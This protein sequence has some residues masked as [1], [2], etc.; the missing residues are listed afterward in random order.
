MSDISLAPRRILP[1]PR[2]FD[3][4]QRLPLVPIGVTLAVCLLILPI[5]FIL[6]LGSF[7]PEKALP[8]DNVGFTLANY[9]QLL[10]DPFAARLFGN[11]FVYAFSSLAVGMVIT[12]MMI[13]LVERTDIPY[14]TFIHVVMFLPIIKPAAISAFGWVI[15]LSP[16]QGLVNVPLRNLLGISGNEGPF[17]IY[18]FPG[19]VFLTAI[20]VVP[21]MFIMLSATFR[22]M[23][24]Q[25]EEAG[26]TA[27]ASAGGVLRQIT[28]PVLFPGILGAG[29]YYTIL[30]FELF[31]IPLIIGFNADYLVIST[32]LYRQVFSESGAPSYSVAAAFGTMALII[33]LGLAYIY[34][35]VTKAAYRYV[36]LTGRRSARRPV[37]LGAWKYPAFGFVLAYLL[38]SIILPIAAL[39]WT[40]LFRTW[41]IPSVNALSNM[42]FDVYR[43]V[44]ADPR[45]GRALQ[46]TFILV[47]GSATITVVLA[48]MISWV[49][50]RNNTLKGGGSKW[51]SLLDAMAFLPRSIPGVVIALAVFLTFIRTDLY[52]TIWII[53]IGHVISYMP[54][55]VRTMHSTLLQIHRELEE[56]AR[57]SGAGTRTVMTSVL[58]PL[59]RPAL[60][61]A[62]VWVAAHSVRDFTFPLM[63][64]ASGNI[65]VAQLLWQV[66]ERGYVER[67]AALSVMLMGGLI[68]LVLPARFF[69]LRKAI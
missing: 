29:I 16:R 35:R 51:V 45:W 8:F 12:I 55:A 66:W 56:A 31:E 34:A 58:F 17:N 54:F 4:T 44:L 23:D 3:G 61:N 9:T 67:A 15:L 10:T 38:T 24:A 53:L 11:T 65:V 18:T 40:S 59:L 20:G 6:I 50:I 36:V 68:L 47:L 69:T 60:L 13:W 48:T 63:L 7:R 57:T 26:R 42:S 37:R 49:V 46:N 2:L 30:L 19:M 1:V 39:I 64:A 25:L 41:T 27:G 62:W 32:F 43:I 21:G 52:A 14:K 28:L 33:G 22:N 5:F